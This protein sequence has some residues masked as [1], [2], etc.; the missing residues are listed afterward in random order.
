M[1]GQ[2]LCGLAGAD[3]AAGHSQI[4]VISPCAGASPQ[5]SSIPE[6][7]KARENL[8]RC[9]GLSWIKAP[10]ARVEMTK[11][12]HSLEHLLRARGVRQL[13]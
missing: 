9:T 1:M 2:E 6:R 12:S 11:L 3:Q 7:T 5:P 10:H 4:L 13:L 8:F